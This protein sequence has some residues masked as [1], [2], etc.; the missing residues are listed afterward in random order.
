MSGEIVPRFTSFAEDSAW[1]LPCSSR[2][3]VHDSPWPV[4]HDLSASVSRM[5]ACHFELLADLITV[6]IFWNSLTDPSISMWK[7]N[8]A[9]I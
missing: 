5:H 3:L 8:A 2:L 6:P 7:K 4:C 1:A 9:G